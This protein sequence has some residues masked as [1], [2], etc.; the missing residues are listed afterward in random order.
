MK[1][2]LLVPVAFLFL[3]GARNPQDNGR[4][5]VDPEYIFSKAYRN[6]WKG[7]P[8]LWRW[9][10]DILTGETTSG[11]PIKRSAFLIWDREVEDFIL[12]I[13]F[14]ISSNGNSGIY[15]RCERGGEGYDDLLGYQADIDGQNTYTGIVYE[16]F[17]NRHRKIL[18]A[19]GQLVRISETDSVHAFSVF[20]S[21]QKMKANVKDNTWNEYEL[22]VRD[23]L[24]IQKLNGQIVSMVEDRSR[25]RVKKGLFGFQLHQGPPMKIAF[26]D[27]RF[28][29]L[30]R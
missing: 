26:R 29:D 9:E 3:T 12:N 20:G 5:S 2:M 4:R 27:A 22:I 19:Q 16:N 30:G 17:I 10:N 18:A 8:G 13:S 1:H 28:I 25:N 24:I 15:Y 21:D 6:Q 23:A 7:S 11:N 14:R